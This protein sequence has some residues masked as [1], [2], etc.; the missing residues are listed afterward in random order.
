V[1]MDRVEVKEVIVCTKARRGNGNAKHSP[2]RVITEIF[3]LNGGLIAEH[4]PAGGIA[5]ESILDFLKYHYPDVEPC[6]H[7]ARIYDYFI[8]EH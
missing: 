2:I 4:D 5:P 7:I 3:N 8:N 6:E 1:D